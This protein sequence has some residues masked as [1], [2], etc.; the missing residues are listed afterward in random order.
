MLTHGRMSAP[1]AFLG[2]AVD[3]PNNISKSLQSLEISSL[4][5][6]GVM[7]SPRIRQPHSAPAAPPSSTVRPSP[8]APC[9]SPT[10]PHP[11]ADRATPHLLQADGDGRMQPSSSGAGEAAPTGAGASLDNEQARENRRSSDGLTS[12]SGGVRWAD[13]P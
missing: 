7:V 5:L 1:R 4:A 9:P 2:Y 12:C 11:I 3:R 10:A 6:I 8:V 13:V